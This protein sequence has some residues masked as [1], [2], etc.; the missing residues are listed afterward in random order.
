MPLTF[1]VQGNYKIDFN[2]EGLRDQIVNQMQKEV[3]YH[4]ITKND[5]KTANHYK[6]CINIVKSCMTKE[7]VEAYFDI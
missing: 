2:S 3:D 5:K 4:E 7:Q 1:N 6:T